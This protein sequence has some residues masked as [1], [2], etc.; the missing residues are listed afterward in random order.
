MNY[1]HTLM[2]L[3]AVAGISFGAMAQKTYSVSLDQTLFIDVPI[4]ELWS[5]TAL[6][7]GSIGKW[8]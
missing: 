3:L 6:D 1:K 5:I 7:F 2:L 8:K 4:D